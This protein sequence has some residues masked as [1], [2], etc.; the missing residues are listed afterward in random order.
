M[1]KL[2]IR[3]AAE[4]LGKTERWIKEKIRSN[5]LKAKKEGKEYK[6]NQSDLNQYKDKIKSEIDRF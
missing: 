5:E 3:E 6:I 4:K 1:K 2:S